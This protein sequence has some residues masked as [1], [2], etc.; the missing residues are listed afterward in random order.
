VR[1]QDAFFVGD[2]PGDLAAARKAGVR[3]SVSCGA[4]QLRQSYSSGRTM[5]CSAIRQRW[6][7]SFSICSLR[8]R[9]EP[10]RKIR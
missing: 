1:H 8:G 10:A 6:A 4:T 7:P 2:Q 9:S 3:G 5:S